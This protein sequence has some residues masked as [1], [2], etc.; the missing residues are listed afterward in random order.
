M[1]VDTLIKILTDY[2]NNKFYTY[3]QKPKNKKYVDFAIYHRH[4]ENLKKLIIILLWKSGCIY[5]SEWKVTTAEFRKELL[6][7]KFEDI[8]FDPTRGEM[9][10]DNYTIYNQ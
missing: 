6:Q 5:E 2:T 4:S 8:I 1:S 7:Y 10:C 9:A 3:F